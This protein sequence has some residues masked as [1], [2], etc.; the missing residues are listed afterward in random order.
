MS[1]PPRVLAARVIERVVSGKDNLDEAWARFA[2]QAKAED[3]ALIQAL[4]YGSL[5]WLPW[6]EAQVAALATRGAW[7]RDA[8][9]R[10][11]LVMGVWEAVGM[12]TPAHA[13]VSETVAAAHT[14][15]RG[16]AS[17]M[18]N[19]VL[20]RL[21]REAY[22]IPADEA[23][24]CA[25]PAWLLEELKR[26]WPQ[27]WQRLI[28]ASN[29][30]PPMSL[31]VNLAHTTREEYSRKLS[32]LG[33]M[34]HP[35]ILVS[36]ALILERPCKVEELPG[37]A[38]GTVAVQDE[39]A[40]LAPYLLEPRAG[41]RVLDACAAPGSKTVH[42]LEHSPGA[43]LTAL[44][45]SSKRLCQVTDNLRRA[46][47][48]AHCVAADAEDLAAWWDGEPFQRI[49]LD[50]PCTASGV[51][52][53]HPDIKWLRG[54]DDA[55]RMAQAQRRLLAA[56]WRVLAPGGRLLFATCSVLPEENEGVVQ[57]F[58]ADHPDAQPLSLAQYSGYGQQ[59]ANGLQ[60][61]PGNA[62][63]SDGFFYSLVL[64]RADD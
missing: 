9:L 15:K 52:R 12:S 43:E 19:A 30:H 35:G 29:E 8:L 24:R 27:S 21:R 33:M 36:S 57:G 6:L 4:V 47:F 53:R 10:S 64:K 31:R 1:H 51:I 59:T 28:Q 16:R 37:F 54:P 49:L 34:A 60:F 58:I 39:A 22:H 7:R 3:R 13:A 11:L 5:R 44:D 62:A 25:F 38:C 56:L 50:A 42:L 55:W 17:G 40:Q 41:E 2:G 63:N 23:D 20:R 14:L 61:L 32:E 48:E 46:G 18:V 45:R 26:A